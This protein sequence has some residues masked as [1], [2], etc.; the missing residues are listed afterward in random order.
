MTIHV[1]LRSSLAWVACLALSV[2][3]KVNRQGCYYL[4]RLGGLLLNRMLEPKPKQYPPVTSKVSKM[5]AKKTKHMHK[6]ADGKM[7]PGAKHKTAKKV[8]K[9][10]Y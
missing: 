7:M 1:A 2:T 9:K 3:P 4:Y 8:P 5:K 6:M 10:K